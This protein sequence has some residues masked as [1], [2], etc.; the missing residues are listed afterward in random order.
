MFHIKLFSSQ[1]KEVD[2]ILTTEG[3]NL[4]AKNENQTKLEM[5]DI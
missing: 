2:L 5:Y 4:G 3:K 1:T